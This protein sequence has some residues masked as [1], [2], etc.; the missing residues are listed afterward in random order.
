MANITFEQF[1]SGVKV[2]GAYTEFDLTSGVKSIPGNPRD[3]VVVAQK[4]T[5]D[6]VFP[7]NTVVEVFSE[8]DVIAHAGA[9]S[10]AHLTAKAIYDSFAQSTL[11]MV[12]QN[13][14]G[15]GVDASG[16]ITISGTPTGSGFLNIWIGSVRLQISVDTTDTATT[17]ASAIDTAI[18]AQADLPVTSSALAGVVTVTAK[19]AGTLGNSIPTSYENNVAGITVA[20]V[21]L[22]GGSV[23]PTF[24]DALDAIFPTTIRHLYSTYNDSTNLGLLKT[25]LADSADPIEKKRRLGWTGAGYLTVGSAN[26]LAN[27]LNDQRIEIAYIRYDKT[28]AQGHSLDYEIGAANLAKYASIE[29]PALPRNKLALDNIVPPSLNEQ[30]SFN[31]Q[32][33]LLINGVAPLAVLPGEGVTIV[34]TVSTKTSTSGVEDFSLLDIQ[35]M[36][37]LDNVAL[38]LE[39][40]FTVRYAR[41]LINDV[42][43]RGIKSEVLAVLL[44][45]QDLERLRDVEENKDRLLVLEDELNRGQV[46]VDVPA[47]VIPG[48]HVI[49]EKITLI[50]N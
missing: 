44:V 48:L 46:N 7:Q 21:Q 2:P 10:V 50:I 8:N 37:T 49:A 32:Q 11:F 20:V 12:Y 31:E 36:D 19:N 17:I 13:D 39:F 15:G 1:P 5:A 40:M 38:A 42:L 4:T 22:T 16:T 23:D 9:G 29:N 27:T 24:Q 18:N 6:T 34:R 41:R 25:H 35:T 45:L 26:S 14:A 30:F 3:I 33:S 47:E 43:L 28:T